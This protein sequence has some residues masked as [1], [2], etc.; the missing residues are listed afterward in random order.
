MPRPRDDT[1]Y[2]SIGIWVLW[3]DPSTQPPT[4]PSIGEAVRR[5]VGS[6]DLAR[7]L[8]HLAQRSTGT[9]R[10]RLIGHAERIRSP[11]V[12]D[13]LEAARV[14]KGYGLPV[15]PLTPGTD[16]L[17]AEIRPAMIAAVEVGADP[18]QPISR[19]L[20]AWRQFGRSVR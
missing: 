13:A 7:A 4:E 12:R 3:L 14:A 11:K 17:F 10:N 15:R 19:I 8:P 16:E 6:P 18:D 9:L 2:L 1:P 5:I 20:R